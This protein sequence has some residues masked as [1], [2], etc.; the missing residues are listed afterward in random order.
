MK[1]YSI[2]Q[3]EQIFVGRVITLKV[4]AITLPNGQTT[5]RE[6]AHIA[7][8]AA[9]LP[10]DA[11]GMVHLVR[12]YRHSVRG[13]VLEIPAGLV[14]EGEDP[15]VCAARELEEEIGL[16]AGKIAKLCAFNGLIG[17]SDSLVHLY[18]GTNLTIG[19]QNLDADEF[20]SVEK[21][22][23]D[24]CEKMIKNGEIIDAKTIM[25][26]AYVRMMPELLE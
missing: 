10:I 13:M 16:K 5:K 8:A 11:D 14:D 4:D 24:E 12:Q 23:I 1:E 2:L 9:L 19:K 3:S 26:I 18:I 6:T 7:D 15:E 22:T 20:I 17:A 21:F 25:A